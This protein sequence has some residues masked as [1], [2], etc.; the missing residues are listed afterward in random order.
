MA[1]ISHDLGGVFRAMLP[2]REVLIFLCVGAA[3]YGVDVLAFNWLRVQPGLDGMDPTV[4]KVL[5]VGVAMVVTYLGNRLLT[6]RGGATTTERRRE[7]GL[8]VAFNLIGLAISVAV[9]VLSHDILD[10]TSRL[11]DNVSANVIGMGL[12]TAFRYWSYRTYV[13]GGPLG[14]APNSGLGS[15][16]SPVNIT[17]ED[18]AIAVLDSADHR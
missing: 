2:S 12:G 15:A 7:I 14:E 8:F 3:G 9:L 13:F 4:S 5:A 1:T 10:L 18:G 17:S 16:A 11:A 6:W